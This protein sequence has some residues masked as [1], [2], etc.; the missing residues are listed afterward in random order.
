MLVAVDPVDVFNEDPVCE[1]LLQIRAFDE[2][3]NKDDDSADVD[4][5]VSEVPCADVVMTLE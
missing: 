5:A 3:V 2:R 1:F 4:A